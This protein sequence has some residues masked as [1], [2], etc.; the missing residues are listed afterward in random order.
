MIDPSVF[1]GWLSELGINFFT[2]IPDSLLKDFCACVADNCPVNSHIV[3]ANEGGAVGLATGYHLSTGKAGLVYMQNSGTGN[4]INPLLSLAD[5]EVYSI[6][7]LVLIGWRGEPDISD[8]PQ[9]RKQGKVQENLIK[10]LEYPYVILSTV[11]ELARS[12]LFDIVS[13]MNTMNSPVV[14]LVRKGTFSAYEPATSNPCDYNMTREEAI[15]V[16]LSAVCKD[17]FIVSTTGMA[18]REIYEIR[19][20]NLQE[21]SH[22]FL[23]VGSMGHAIM[24]ALGIALNADKKVY[25]IDGDGAAIMHLGSLGIVASRKAK[26][27]RHIVINNGAHDSVGGQKTIGYAIDFPRLAGQLGYR[28]VYSAKDTVELSHALTEMVKKDGLSFLEVRV[29][30]GARKD[31]GRPKMSPIENKQAFMALLKK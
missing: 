31:L 9:H 24:I 27:L 17:D 23:T 28:N 14:I 4:A 26:N 25:C 2:G 8:E 1:V 22:D 5:P 15:K 16:I 13:V 12:Q 6:P 21:H 3:T 20:S 10:S 18:S 7:M 11:P 29:K 30:C 19:E